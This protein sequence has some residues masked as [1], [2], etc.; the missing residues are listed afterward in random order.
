MRE[1][2]ISRG[3]PPQVSTWNSRRKEYS[4]LIGA[5]R[6]LL[7]QLSTVV[8]TAGNAAEPASAAAEVRVDM[9]AARARSGRYVLLACELAY[10][11]A[12]GKMDADETREALLKG[13]LLVAGEW[14]AMAAGERHTVVYAWIQA[15]VVQ[16][17][18]SPPEC[19]LSDYSL[20]DCSLPD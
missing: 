9:G 2:H 5:S 1:S 18:R 4:S 17:S 10:A 13:R 12:R 8:S 3:D 14:E 11:K 7:I 16:L 6:N 15:R 19:S 20:P